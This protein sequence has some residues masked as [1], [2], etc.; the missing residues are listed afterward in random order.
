MTAKS[1]PHTVF[2]IADWFL[3]KAKSEGKDLKH[4]KLQKLVYFAYGWY[5]AYFDKPLFPE[6]ICAWQHG[7]V[8]V[9]LYQKYKPFKEYPIEVDETANPQV[10]A[11]VLSILVEVWET[12]AYC[13]DSHLR[14]IT[15]R[16]DAP[17]SKVYNRRDR[18]I[19]IPPSDI[20]NYFKTLKNK[21]DNGK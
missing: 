21:Y 15:H 20:Q 4:M 16:P 10:E 8:V 17:W 2:D 13:T 5:I 3:A 18:S 9:E 11:D 12:Y 7:P 6:T 19:E 14:N 1:P